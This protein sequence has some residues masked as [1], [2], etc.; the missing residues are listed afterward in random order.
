MNK[1]FITIDANCRPT[2]HHTSAGAT[3]FFSLLSLSYPVVKTFRN[4]SNSTSASSAQKKD[5]EKLERCTYSGI[6]PHVS[7][8]VKIWKG[9]VALRSKSSHSTFAALINL[10]SNVDAVVYTYA[11]ALSHCKRNRLQS[12]GIGSPI[13]STAV[14]SMINA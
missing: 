4:R 11:R 7:L 3:H 1:H 2:F 9:A 6:L 8:G 14:Q 13:R 5:Y 12:N 10:G